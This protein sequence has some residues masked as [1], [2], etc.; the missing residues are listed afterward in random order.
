VDGQ[1]F[2]NVTVGA[3]GQPRPEP[4]VR[5]GTAHGRR[6]HA[7]I[8]SCPVRGKATVGSRFC[9]IRKSDIA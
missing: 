6:S 2:R 1:Q 7:T 4:D 9:T 8:L 5:Q 3:L